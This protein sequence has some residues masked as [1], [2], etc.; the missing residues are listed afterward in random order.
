MIRSLQKCRPVALA[1]SLAA[2]IGLGIS[3]TAMAEEFSESKL[4]SFATAWTGINQLAER[5]KPQVEAAASEEQ[6]VEMLQ[7]FEAEA[8]QVIET[9][10]GIGTAEYQSIVEA[11]QSDPA[12]NERIVAM[13][14]AVQQ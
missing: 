8:N 10:E 11:A 3:G 7:Q 9:T 13:L 4:K 1:L 2:F 12:L 14:Q 5:W 6:A